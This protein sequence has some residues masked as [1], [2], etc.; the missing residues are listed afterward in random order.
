MVLG[1]FVAI[2]MVRVHISAEELMVSGYCKFYVPHWF[3]LGRPRS[4]DSCIGL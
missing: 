4:L 3:P 2:K 1:L